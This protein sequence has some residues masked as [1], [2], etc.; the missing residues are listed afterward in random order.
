M[1]CDCVHAVTPT[2]AARPARR[3]HDSA[4][5]RRHTRNQAIISQSRMTG[6]ATQN[7]PQQRCC[8]QPTSLASTCRKGEAARHG[9]RPVPAV[10]VLVTARFTRVINL[11]VTVF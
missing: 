8:V 3:A 9:V 5:Q 4:A 11:D 2:L 7:T 1:V 10:P 6:N